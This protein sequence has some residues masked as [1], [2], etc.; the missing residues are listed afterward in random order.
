[1]PETTIHLRLRTALF[2]I[3]ERELRGRAFVGSDQFVYWD[4]TNPR[5]CLAPDVLVRL[6]GPLGFP[7]SFKTWEHGAPHI[8]VEIISADDS[9]DRNWAEKLERYRRSGVA[10]LV[11][12]DPED[13]APLRIWDLV[14]GDMVERD[15]SDPDG[16]RCD[17]LQAYWYVSDDPTLGKML[18]LA[19]KPDGK[20]PL[21]TPEEAE[22]Q[23]QR[24]VAELERE[25]ARRGG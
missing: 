12:F 20:E 23:S 2:L 24:R 16:R 21:L 11:R 25:L 19:R 17:A 18:R 10:E 13:D 7:R 9:R 8:A 15:L 1:V 4:P 5:A 22:Q 14:E 3:L 6:E